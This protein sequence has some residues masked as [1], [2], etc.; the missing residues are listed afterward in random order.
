MPGAGAS[1]TT[2]WWRRCIEQSLS[3]RWTTLPCWSAITCISICLGVFKNFS[4]YTSSLPKKLKASVL[5]SSMELESSSSDSTIRIPRPPPPPE[6]LMI[7]GK[8]IFFAILIFAFTFSPS[9]PLEPGTQGT[10]EFC[11]ASIA[12]TLSPI[13]RIFSALGPIKIKPL[14]STCS[15]KSAFSERKPYPG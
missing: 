6:A 9:E 3:P 5:V 12:A 11:I 2:F 8:P 14:C 15:A 4:I 10:P 7:I 13:M 1:S